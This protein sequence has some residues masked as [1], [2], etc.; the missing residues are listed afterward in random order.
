[1]S[2]RHGDKPCREGGAD[3]RRAAGDG[4]EGDQS[5]RTAE[6]RCSTTCAR[7]SPPT[8]R[9]STAMSPAGPFYG[10]NRPGAKVSEGVDPELVASG[11]DGRRQGALRRHQGVLGD[12]FHRRPQEDHGA[13]AGDAR[14]GRSDRALCRLRAAVGQ[15]AEERDAEDLQGLPARHADHAC[16]IINADLLAFIK[17]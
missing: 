15:A 4:E 12:R 17:S 1:M 10:F 13:G 2:R 16:R 9:N 7:R 5:R 11:H 8:A 6:S 14:R 3:R